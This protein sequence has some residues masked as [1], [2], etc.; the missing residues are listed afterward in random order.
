[1][2]Y[3]RAES[4]QPALVVLDGLSK[5][6]TENLLYA[7]ATNE[8]TGVELDGPRSVWGPSHDGFTVHHPQGCGD[9]R[10]GS[11]GQVGVSEAVPRPPRSWTTAAGERVPS[12][13]SAASWIRFQ[14]NFRVAAEQ[15]LRSV[16]RTVLGDG[17]TVVIPVARKAWSTASNTLVSRSTRRGQ[18]S[19]PAPGE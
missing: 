4:L 18:E 12:W 9:E 1:M 16:S 14:A 6:E 17:E 10:I 8:Q 2:D 15:V 7:C 5:R 19:S 13:G 3:F 11:C